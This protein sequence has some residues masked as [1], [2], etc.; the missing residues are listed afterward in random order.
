MTESGSAGSDSPE[1]RTRRREFV[2][3]CAMGGCGLALAASAASRLLTGDGPKA[4]S[5]G[6][7][8]DPP[9]PDWPYGRE[10][11]WY[12]EH[13]GTITCRLCPHQCVLREDD[14]GFC[15]V[16]AVKD[17]KLLTLVYGNPCSLH[18]DPLEKKPLYHF[19]PGR[20]VLSLAT[21]GCNL[22]CLNCQNWEI[23]QARPEDI[24][25]TPVSP[26][27][28]VGAAAEK[29][30]P[31]IAYTYSEPII[32]YEYTRDC[33]AL[34]KEKGIRNV[35]VT[36]G[37]IREEPLR[38]L[39]KVTDAAN[40]DL[41]SFSDSTYRRLNR[42]R[43]APILR[44]L[45]IM[46]EEGV[47]V[48]LT[49]LIVPGYSDDVDD[50][51]KMCEWIHKSLGPD[52]PLHISRFHPAYRLQA[53]PPTPVRILEQAHDIAKS[54]GLHHVYIGNVPGRKGQNT[55]CPSCGREVIV[56]EGYQVQLKGLAAGKCACGHEIAGVWS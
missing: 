3:R 48:E 28:L 17:H 42:A 40:V 32:F 10:A 23:S 50:L 39:C 6:F 46:R 44:T 52:V 18:I 24:P 54:A 9:K 8:N 22:R 35:L 34:A 36:A 7:T 33:S 49:R 11:E 56:R 20:A 4:M 19:L 37:Y 27:Q 30:I 51:T 2:K 5:M 29:A 31:A 16:R 12:D 38:A 15:R 45:E 21:A 25:S 14:R 55:L 1:A 41:K 26:Q 53:L 13:L 43:L 47:W